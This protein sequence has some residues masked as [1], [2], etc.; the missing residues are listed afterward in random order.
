MSIEPLED[1]LLLASGICLV[2]AG[3]ID[4]RS[5]PIAGKKKN[6]NPA[7][8][9]FCVGKTGV[10]GCVPLSRQCAIPASGVAA[11]TAKAINT[12]NNLTSKSAPQ[13]I[14]RKY[15]KIIDS[16][17]PDEFDAKAMVGVDEVN[18]YTVLQSIS[19]KL[20]KKPSK[21]GDETWGHEI[22]FRVNDSLDAG[23]SSNG[24]KVFREAMRM[25][26][27]EV[28][29]KLPNGAIVLNEPYT[30]DG[31]GAKRAKLYERQGFGPIGK[32]GFQYGIVQNGKILPID[33]VTLKSKRW[34]SNPNL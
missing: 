9:H 28:V 26:A 3:T 29:K 14:P 21:G 11:S 24:I 22:A 5:A 30:K 16:F 18:V 34:Y 32:S 2:L 13:P 4:Y 15:P 7:K 10:G 25:A 17:P 31:L 12:A 1:Q 19:E 23:T 27:D 6:C 20:G 33:E 8:S